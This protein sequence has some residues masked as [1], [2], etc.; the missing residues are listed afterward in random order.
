MKIIKN[1]LITTTL[2]TSAAQALTLEYP[3]LYKDPRVMSMGGAN[4]AVGGES[5]AMFSNP[6]GLSRLDPNEGLEVDLINIGL[7]FSENT[8][9]L[10]DDL[11]KANTDSETLAVLEKY[12]GVN[13]HLTVNDYSSISYKGESIAWSLGLLPLSSQFNFKTHALGSS[14]GLLDINAYALSGLI[15]GLSYDFT[16]YLHIGL[17]AKVL[18]GKSVTA[19]LS[20]TEVLDLTDSSTDSA[21]YLEDTYMKDF[22]TTSYDAGLIIDL[23]AF[24]PYGNYWRPSIG[25]S[26]LDIGETKLGDYGTIPTTVNIGALIQPKIPYLSNFLLAVDYI[27]ILDEYATDYDADMGKKWRLGARADIFHNS[28][29]QLTGSGGMYNL[30][31]T[32]GVEIRLSLLTIAYS[33]YAE[34]LG[35]YAGQD[36]DRRHSLS[37]AL[38]W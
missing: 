17:G 23:D 20:L 5:S 13:N 8:L 2:L 22:K 38:G 26:I 28:W 6:A 18:E 15:A 25:L 27:D 30:E 4:V 9:D 10:L 29:V 24:I 7:S 3:S 19:S 37:V 36:L 16:N 35:A 31:P 12:Q 34:E 32:Y 21:Q 33:S 1:L 11:D 14:S